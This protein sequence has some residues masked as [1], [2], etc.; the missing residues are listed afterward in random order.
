MLNLMLH[1]LGVA[2]AGF[3]YCQIL[4]DGGMLLNPW[5][6]FLDRTIGPSSGDILSGGPGR[7]EWLFK[8]VGGCCKCTT[9]QLALWSYFVL[10]PYPGSLWLLHLLHHA[11]FVTFA[12]YLVKFVAQAY[13]P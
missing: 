6:N 8:M 7:A 12:V 10:F 5:Y 9:G 13:E 3:T 11:F 2:V 1:A 4:M